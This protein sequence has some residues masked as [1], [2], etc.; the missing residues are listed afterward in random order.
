MQTRASHN[1]VFIALRAADLLTCLPLLLLFLQP[2]LTRAGIT[3]ITLRPS[4]LPSLSS[5][6]P[7]HDATGAALFHSSFF[8][9]L[10]THERPCFST[11]ILLF[12][13]VLSLIFLLTPA[14]CV[15]V[16]GLVPSFFFNPTPHPQAGQEPL[17]SPEQRRQRSQLPHPPRPS[18]PA[19]A[20][21]PLAWEGR[22]SSS[23]C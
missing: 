1:R 7:P 5:K 15:C 14:F 16:E 20:S 3:F 12:L 23:P 8:F 4:L 21:P 6:V 10:N 9:A 19:P 22:A 18:S 2:L 17:R 11:H 13:L